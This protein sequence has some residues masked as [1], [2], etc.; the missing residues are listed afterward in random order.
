MKRIIFVVVYLIAAIIVF[1][2]GIEKMSAV[3]ENETVTCSNAFASKCTLT[4][5]CSYNIAMEANNCI[6]TCH[7]RYTL[8][9]LEKE[10]IT[11][12]NCGVWKKS[13]GGSNFGDDDSEDFDPEGDGTPWEDPLQ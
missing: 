13:S 11:T 9:G 10:K 3:G 12:V 4:G 2:V 7:T 6:I 5:S 8:N 1:S